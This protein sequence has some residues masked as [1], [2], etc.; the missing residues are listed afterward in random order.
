MQICMFM[1][2]CDNNS[3][4][5]FVCQRF[6]KE[7][8]KICVTFRI[9]EKKNLSVCIN[10]AFVRQRKLRNYDYTI[11]AG[12]TWNNCL[13]FNKIGKQNESNLNIKTV[14][15][16]DKALEVQDSQKRKKYTLSLI[17]HHPLQLTAFCFTDTTKNVD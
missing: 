7:C 4:K 17:N 6:V 15:E 12:E 2:L 3:A 14:L 11:H 1:R 16:I 8:S 5:N 13:S 9:F 10:R